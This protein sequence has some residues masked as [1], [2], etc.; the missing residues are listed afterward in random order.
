MENLVQTNW[1]FKAKS[2][3]INDW[4]KMRTVM[5]NMMMKI[6]TEMKMMKAMKTRKQI[7]KTS[8][9]LKKMKEVLQNML[10]LTI[11]CH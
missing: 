5:E 7:E 2:L 1:Y 4:K 3:R 9:G 6:N 8:M 11:Y 10:K